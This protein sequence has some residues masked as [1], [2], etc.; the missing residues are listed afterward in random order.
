MNRMPPHIEMM[1][2]KNPNAVLTERGI[3]LKR[4]DR[5]DE[6]LS[7]IP[8]ADELYGEHFDEIKAEQ[9]ENLRLATGLSEET[10]TVG[11]QDGVIAPTVEKEADLDASKETSDDKPETNDTSGLAFPGSDD[12]RTAKEVSDYIQEANGGP[13]T[14]DVAFAAAKQNPKYAELSDE[15]ITKRVQMSLAAKERMAKKKAEDAK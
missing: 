7:G 4:T 5:I 2:H 14:F 6:L 12:T 15:E 9:A 11:E 10:E 8:N 13:D 1:I 3:V